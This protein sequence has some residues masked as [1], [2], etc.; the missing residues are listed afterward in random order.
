MMY[1]KATDLEAA[2]H[3]L[4][5]EIK[6]DEWKSDLE[7]D[8][9]HTK[10]RGVMREWTLRLPLRHQG[11]IVTGLRG[12]DGAGKEDASKAL[13][14]MI[15]RAVLNPAD[16][17]ETLK[18]GGFFGF[19]PERLLRDTLQLLHSID[20]Y[21]LHYI[22]HLMH[23]CQV[24]AFKHPDPTFRQFFMIVY[25][26]MVHKFHLNQESIED[27]DARL[28]TDRIAAGTTERDF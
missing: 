3:A 19:N 15:R 13:N 4:P 1:W 6:Q 17:R 5:A 12:C 2:I 28:T 11:V 18:T 20:Q 10:Y 14:C 24:I 16:E 7:Q 27:M 25:A 26:M 9:S 22:T 21:P 23:A 8:H